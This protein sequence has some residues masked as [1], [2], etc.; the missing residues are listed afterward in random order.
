VATSYPLEFI[1]QLGSQFFFLCRHLC[2]T[3]RLS[4]N[5]PFPK[6]KELH[7]QSICPPF[8]V[9]FLNG[10]RDG[11]PPA[12]SRRGLSLGWRECY[13]SPW[14]ELSF[15]LAACVL[16]PPLLFLAAGGFLDRLAWYTCDNPAPISLIGRSPLQEEE[17]F[18]DST[19]EGL[20]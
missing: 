15:F 17:F 11:I 12:S 8:P 16:H 4:S 2:S 1:S 13:P 19:G 20:C 9:A 14:K 10:D 3:A 5:P 18:R 7:L 6:K